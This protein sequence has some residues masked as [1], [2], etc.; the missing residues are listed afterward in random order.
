M[1]EK[2]RE[3]IFAEHRDLGYRV[4][5]Q[6]SSQWGP[7]QWCRN[8]GRWYHGYENGTRELN[9]NTKVWNTMMIS[10]DDAEDDTAFR[11]SPG[12]W[13]HSWIRYQLWAISHEV[14]W[15]CPAEED[16]TRRHRP[17]KSKPR[18]W[19]FRDK[20]KTMLLIL[21][22]FWSTTLQAYACVWEK[23]MSYSSYT[24]HASTTAK[25]QDVPSY[26]ET[27][28]LRCCTV[29][30]CNVLPIPGEGEREPSNKAR[31]MKQT[32]KMGKAQ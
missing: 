32:G 24:T 25:A 17:R 16:N 27:G 28:T 30:Y 3:Q 10:D 22:A 12:G 7:R 21:L 26:I 23:Y 5:I 11:I 18:L 15:R 31:R 8:R 9:P 14:M 20:H 6:A 29:M 13:I 1:T 19:T 2:V 4:I